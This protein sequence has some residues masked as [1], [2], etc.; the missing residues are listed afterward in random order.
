VLGAPAIAHRLEESW[1]RRWLSASPVEGAIRGCSQAELSEGAHS[2]DATRRS[3]ASTQGW[4]APTRRAT[5]WSPPMRS[6]RTTGWRCRAGPSDGKL[7]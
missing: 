2:H 7:W 5:G 1:V 6:R 3:T 4:P